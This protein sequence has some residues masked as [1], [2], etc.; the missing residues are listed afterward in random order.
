MQTAFSPGAVLIAP[1]SRAAA[2]FVVGFVLAEKF[3]ENAEYDFMQD[4]QYA[5]DRKIV[6]DFVARTFAAHF[7]S[8]GRISTPA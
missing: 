6:Q 3:R 4:C 8:G 1:A 5:D 2:E 7:M